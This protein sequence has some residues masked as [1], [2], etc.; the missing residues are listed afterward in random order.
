MLSFLLLWLS[1]SVCECAPINFFYFNERT[2][3]NWN[4]E[5]WALVPVSV[6]FQKKDCSSNVYCMK[7]LGKMHSLTNKSTTT[8]FECNLYVFSFIS[9]FIFEGK[10]SWNKNTKR[11][12]KTLKCLLL[13]K[14]K[15]IFQQSVNYS[16]NFEFFSLRLQICL[17]LNSFK[18]RYS[19]PFS[20]ISIL[21]ACA[22]HIYLEPHEFYS[23]KN[24]NDTNIKWNEAKQK[25]LL[26]ISSRSERIGP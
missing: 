12:K 21:F 9:S 24:T 18:Y 3:R 10:K 11:T 15:Y 13:I 19:V 17:L 20:W 4:L 23:S 7:Y 2:K 25:G 16:N 6:L 26:E 5:Y 1:E 22:F 8:N 14:L